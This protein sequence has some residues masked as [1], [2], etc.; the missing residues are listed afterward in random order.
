MNRLSARNIKFIAEILIQSSN[1]PNFKVKNLAIHSDI[2]SL[3]IKGDR[4]SQYTLYKLYSKAMY[5]IC[6]RMLNNKMDAED[7]L[8]SAFIDVFRNLNKFRGDSS[9]GSWIKRIVINNCLNHI[10]KNKIYFEDLSDK[11]YDIKEEDQEVQKYDIN[12][13]NNAIMSLPEGYRT[14]LNLYLMEGYTHDEIAGILDISVSTSKSQFS[15]AKQ[16]LKEIIRSRAHL[17]LEI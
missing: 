8:Q 1:N 17:K 11:V 6:L 13:V 7:V 5:N 12:A 10:K 4:D 3:C 16:K 14:V 15:R 2:V 9:I